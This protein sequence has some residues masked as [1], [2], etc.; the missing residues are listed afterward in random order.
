MSWSGRR[1]FSVLSLLVPVSRLTLVDL[2]AFS[3]SRSDLSESWV[4]RFEAMP[5]LDPGSGEDQ[6]KCG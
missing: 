2:R 5:A 3:L 6:G 1:Y 4:E